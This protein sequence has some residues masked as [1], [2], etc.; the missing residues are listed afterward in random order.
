MY[1]SGEIDNIVKEIRRLS[2]KIL[3]VCGVRWH[4]VGKVVSNGVT[5]LYSRGTDAKY[6]HGVGI[7]LDQDKIKNLS[8]FWCISNRVMLVRFRGRSSD[9]IVIQCYVPTSNCAVEEMDKF[10]AHHE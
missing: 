3:G 9:T 1:H 8:G 4:G 6:E 2:I 5:F 7:F 10:Y